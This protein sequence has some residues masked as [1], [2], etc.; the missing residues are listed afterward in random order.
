MFFSSGF[1]PEDEEVEEAVSLSPAPIGK[2]SLEHS[3]SEIGDI[4][5]EGSVFL[6]GS[7][8]CDNAWDDNEA[9]VVCR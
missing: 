9:L 4:L 7:P 3:S 5:Y 2:I 6:D 1:V 8:V